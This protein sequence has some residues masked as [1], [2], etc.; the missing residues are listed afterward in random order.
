[1]SF[2]DGAGR[3]AFSDAT[4]NPARLVEIIEQ[5]GFTAEAAEPA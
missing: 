2:A 5:A 3:I 1:V 4:I